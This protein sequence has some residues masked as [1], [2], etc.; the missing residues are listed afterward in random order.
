MASFK[1]TAREVSRMSEDVS[2]MWMKRESGPTNSDTLVRKAITSCLTVRS[3]SSMRSTSKR[4][5]C[6]IV[7]SAF[8]G[9]SPFCAKASQARISMS[10]HFWN[11]F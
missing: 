6:L 7:L 1:S 11:R 5:F 2:P 8:R 9:I 3:I 4:A 10:S